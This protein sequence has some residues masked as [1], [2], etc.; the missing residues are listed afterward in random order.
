MHENVNELSIQRANAQFWEQMLA[1]RLEPIAAPDLHCFEEQVLASCDLSG[2]WVGR[3]EIRMS[4]GLA[5]VATAAM[6][7]QPEAKVQA[8]DLLDAAK[9]IANMIAGTMKSA[10][11][12]PCVMTVP[13]AELVSETNCGVLDTWDSVAAYFQHAEGKLMVRV[14]EGVLA[15]V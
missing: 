7:M 10:L 15:A 4:R 6:L 8:E 2:A 5:L 12:R 3:I 11:P 1:M 9:E 14:L 13:E